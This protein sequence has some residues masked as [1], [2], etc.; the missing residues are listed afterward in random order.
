[1]RLSAPDRHESR[2]DWG[3][4]ALGHSAYSI[5]QAL[6]KDQAHFQ[7]QNMKYLQV[8]NDIRELYHRATLRTEG[9]SI[10]FKGGHVEVEDNKMF[11]RYWRSILQQGQA[12]GGSRNGKSSHQSDDE[13]FEILFP[14]RWGNVLFGTRNG[15]TWFQTE[16]YGF[17]ESAKTWNG[18]K[19]T[20]G[21]AS[22]TV[23]YYGSFKTRQ[24][25]TAGCSKYT[26]A[27]PLHLIA[28]LVP[29]E[30]T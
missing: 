16:A 24:V 25:G 17:T 18:M 21:H 29:G 14:N 28:N 4:A 27:S 10:V 8:I 20:I 12:R 3:G 30:P 22:T 7:G 9:G 1:M 15:G 11:Y 5:Y 13:Q 6:L 19:D 23:Q 2:S 26:E